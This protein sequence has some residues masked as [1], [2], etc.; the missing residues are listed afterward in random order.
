LNQARV[1]LHVPSHMLPDGPE[2]LPSF[3]RRLLDGL[4]ALGAHTEVVERDY[5]RLFAGPSG[6]DFD[7]VHNG[8]V[9]RQQALNLGPAYLG[10]FFYV[11][12]KGIFFES[13]IAEMPFR[14]KAISAERAAEFAA[15]LRQQ[16]VEARK[17]RHVQREARESFGTGHIAIFLQDWSDPVV[18]ARYMDGMQMVRCVLAH[19]QGRPVVV[20]PHPRNIGPETAEICDFLRRKH[21][22]VRITQ[23]NIHDIL[24]GAAATVSIA[25]SV[26]MEGM[27]HSVPALL[28][29]RSDMHPCAQTV[30]RKQDWPAALERALGH[31]WPYEKFL[32][33][34]LKRQNIWAARPFLARV[35][36]RMQAKG[37]DFNALGLDRTRMKS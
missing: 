22:Q 36:D 10:R 23:A 28:F 35:L 14:P 8:N 13:A 19:S 16:W 25:S 31:D 21:P 32:F 37:A 2:E 5:D 4:A 1:R 7:F 20:K 18:R 17:S 24:Q 26:A 9:A 30:T 6:A 27:L 33:W 34:F 29:G 15:L 12:P 3:Y 11:D